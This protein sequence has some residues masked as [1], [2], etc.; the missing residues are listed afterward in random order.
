M[1][2]IRLS[3]DSLQVTS[4]ETGGGRREP[5]TVH[6]HGTQA[7]QQTCDGTCGGWLTVFTCPPMSMDASCI[8]SCTCPIESA[9]CWETCGGNC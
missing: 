9:P 2:K 5:G 6:A 4:F 3:L 8:E 7:Q 1:N